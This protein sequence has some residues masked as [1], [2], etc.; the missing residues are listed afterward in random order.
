[1]KK[2]LLILLMVISLLLCG[3]GKEEKE[4]PKENPIVT[5]IIKDYGE[6]KI[7]LYPEYAFNTVANFVNL[8]ESGYYDGN[9]F[10]RVQKGFVIQGGAGNEEKANYSIKGEFKSNGY[11]KNTLTHS[12]GVI[13]MARTSDPNSACGQFFIV[14][15]DDAAMSLDGMYA[16]FGKVIEGMDIFTKIEARDDFEYSEDFTGASMGFLADDE[17]IYIEKATVD[18]KGYTYKVEKN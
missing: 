8:V 2:K 4:M 16:G 9:Y 10:N 17:F 14:L 3:C 1:M 13:S 15:S 11:S 18:T 7:E 12:T 5:M 6:V